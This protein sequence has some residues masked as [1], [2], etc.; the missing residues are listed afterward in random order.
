MKLY[1]IDTSVVVKWYNQE[2]EEYILK[3]QKI[4]D[5]FGQGRISLLAPD[6]IGIELINVFIKGKKLKSVEIKILLNNFFQLP[7]IMKEPT[8]QLLFQANVTAQE[9]NITSYDALFVAL[10]K[11]EECQLISD[12]H[13]GHGKINDER[14]VM[15]KDYK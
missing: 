10:A 14:V 5:D 15:L 3:A 6:L 12:D 8:E 4:L 1:V 13:I 2:N 7:L 9:N 11:L